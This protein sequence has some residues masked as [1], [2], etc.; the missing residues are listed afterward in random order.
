MLK[1]CY[2]ILDDILLGQGFCGF[3]SLFLDR[4][5]FYFFYK[6]YYQSKFKKYG[7]NIRWGRDFRRLVIPNSLRISC[8]EKISIG[9]FCQI[10]EFVYLQCDFGEFT[11]AEIKIGNK[12]RIN[13]NVHLLAGSEIVLEDE[14]LVAPY[15]LITS[16]NHRFDL[17]KSIMSQGMKPSGRVVIG[18]GSWIGQSAKILGGAL[19]GKNSVVGS[20]AIVL[21]GNYPDR[22]KIVG[23]GTTSKI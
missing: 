3:L 22:S 18:K 9:D 10:D 21:K 12:V 15:S 20:G 11:D 13:A 23:N 8:P 6:Y 5:K 17:D 19:M 7:K 1:K 16:N 14:V 4:I 2:Q